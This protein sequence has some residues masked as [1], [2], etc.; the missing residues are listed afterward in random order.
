MA[1]DQQYLH[2]LCQPAPSP[3]HQPLATCTEKRL[4][5]AV[6]VRY[7]GVGIVAS[8]PTQCFNAVGS[9]GYLAYQNRHLLAYTL[10]YPAG[11]QSI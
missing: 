9:F 5:E 2:D 6:N 3:N 8:N 1:T 10:T 7:A 11:A 4:S